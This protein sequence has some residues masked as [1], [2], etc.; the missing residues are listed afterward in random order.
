MEEG[1]AIVIPETII[2][3]LPKVGF[4]IREQ[5]QPVTLQREYLG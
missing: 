3:L 4:R 1:M 5:D 2:G